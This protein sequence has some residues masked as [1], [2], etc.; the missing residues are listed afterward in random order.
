M[1]KQGRMHA[2]GKLMIRVKKKKNSPSIE[3]EGKTQIRYDLLLIQSP[4][5]K[6]KC[7]YLHKSI[8]IK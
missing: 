4:T 8:I 3:T 6:I 7:I 1:R 5:L 2:Y